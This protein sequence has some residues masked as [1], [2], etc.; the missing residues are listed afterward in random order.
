[1]TEPEGFALPDRAALLSYLKEKI[2]AC[3]PLFAEPAVTEIE[4]ATVLKK[5]S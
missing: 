4:T 1:M 3:K 2:V 5:S